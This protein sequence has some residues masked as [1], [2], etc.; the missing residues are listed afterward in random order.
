MGPTRLSEVEKAQTAITQTAMRLEA[1]GRI[2]V[3]KGGS[4]DQFV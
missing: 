2:V 4:D 1:E 3:A